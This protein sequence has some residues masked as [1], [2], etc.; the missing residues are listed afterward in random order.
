MRPDGLLGTVTRL[1]ERVGQLKPNGHLVRRAP[2]S[3]L[4]GVEGT[5]EAL[6][7]KVAG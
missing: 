3:D 1:S 2:L 7:R 5:L 6:Q 4:V